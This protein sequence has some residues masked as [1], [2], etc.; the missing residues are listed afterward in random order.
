[1]PRQSTAFDHA[2]HRHRK[3]PREVVGRALSFVKESGETLSDIKQKAAL[4]LR[5]FVAPLIEQARLSIDAAA[6][7]ARTEVGRIGETVSAAR[8]A[9]GDRLRK[10]EYAQALFA[11]RAIPLKRE[12]AG[13]STEDPAQWLLGFLSQHPVE[14]AVATFAVTALLV[15]G[16]VWR[17]K[18]IIERQ[19]INAEGE[20]KETY[21][22]L[23]TETASTKSKVNYNDAG[24][25]DFQKRRNQQ[26]LQYLEKYRGKQATRTRDSVRGDYASLLGSV[27]TR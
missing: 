20:R 7:G 18:L 14:A 17:R 4:G 12:Q 9:L 3:L 25:S 19:T 2:P 1:M 15:G 5:S 24:A 16:G 23:L 10:P 26:I 22:K 13:F 27:V 8:V 11:L 6:Q 21:S